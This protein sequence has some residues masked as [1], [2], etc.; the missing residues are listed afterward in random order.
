MVNELM[1]FVVVVVVEDEKLD[2]MKRLES[3][4][5]EKTMGAVVAFSHSKMSSVS[6]G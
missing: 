5:Q 3:M 2:E 6:F 1:M 4:T